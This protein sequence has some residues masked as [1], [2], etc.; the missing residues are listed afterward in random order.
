MPSA[1]RVSQLEEANDRLKETEGAARETMD[2]LKEENEAMLEALQEAQ[3]ET[4][5][6]RETSR[7]LKE[8]IIDNDRLTVANLNRIKQLEANTEDLRDQVDGLEKENDNL[9]E[10][11]SKSVSVDADEEITVLRELLAEREGQLVSLTQ[12]LADTTGPPT[13][14]AARR[15]SILDRLGMKQFSSTA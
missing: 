8:E 7:K 2:A 14:S 12:R 1:G 3:S 11:L 15:E 13:T 4:E 5:L 10:E 6:K 9:R